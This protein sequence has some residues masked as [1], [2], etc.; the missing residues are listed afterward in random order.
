MVGAHRAQRRIGDE[1]HALVEL[2]RLVDLPVRDRLHVG[3]QAT[4][5]GPVT[6]RVFEQRL[7]LADPDMS[8][9]ALQPVVEDAGGDLAALA[10]ARAVAEEEALAVAR[11]PPDRWSARR[12]RLAGL[13]VPGSIWLQAWPA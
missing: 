8:A 13:K 10:R 2:D 7:V 9:P 4:K 5:R 1:Q 6:P 3:R 11:C 12:L